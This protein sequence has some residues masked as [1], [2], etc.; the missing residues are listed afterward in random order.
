MEGV[1]VLHQ[2]IHKFH[3]KEQSGV[4]FKIKFEKAYDEVNLAFVQQT[5]RMKGFSS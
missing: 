5:L 1:I 2:M 4:I 3:R